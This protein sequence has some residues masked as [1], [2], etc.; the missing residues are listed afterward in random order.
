MVL[1]ITAYRFCIDQRFDAYIFQMACIADTGQHQQLRRVDCASCQD[2]FASC[3]RLYACALRRVRNTDCAPS[4][5][6]YACCLRPGLQLQR[7]AF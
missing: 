4:L 5:E 2:N 7:L 3:L 1:Q 6:Q